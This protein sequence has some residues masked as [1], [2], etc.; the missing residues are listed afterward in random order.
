[1]ADKNNSLSNNLIKFT[2]PLSLLAGILLYL[3]GG[4]VAHY[5]GIQIDW[6]VYWLGQGCIILL[7][8]SSSFLKAYYDFPQSIRSMRRDRRVPRQDEDERLLVKTAVLQAAFTTLA[9]GSVLTV[10]LYTRGSINLTTLF[11]L[12]TAFLI[13]FFYAVPPPQLVYSGYGELVFAIFLANLTPAFAFSLQ[14]GDLHRLLAMLTFPLTSLLLAVILAL[15]L[16]T[17]AENIKTNRRTL[18]V[19]I[20]WQLGFQVHHLMVLL[21]YLVIGIAAFLGLPW[22]LGWPAFL[23]LPIALYQIWI[24]NQIAVGKSPNWKILNLTAAVTFGLTA[25][26][27]TFAL[28]TG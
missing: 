28:W 18:M 3:L 9:T 2:Q 24:I 13:A 22:E 1:M 14:A 20:G 15:S 19:R 6:L 16:K 11:I 27:I 8:L 25:Y 4:G 21:A 17:H 23:T 26:L 5:M 12:G 7:I 10:L